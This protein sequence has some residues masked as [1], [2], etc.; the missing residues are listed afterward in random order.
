AAFDGAGFVLGR[1][2]ALGIAREVALKFKEVCVTPA[3]AFSAAEF[4]HGPL[5][6][7]GAGTPLLVLCL[8]DATRPGVID[9]ARR[10]AA[11]GA[12]VTLLGTALDD[13]GAMANLTV[14]SRASTGNLYTDA[15]ALAFDCYVALESRA[16]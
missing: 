7:V 4:I 11:L 3:E 8:N 16:V 1:G 6:L 2:L 15:I 12:H 9:I 14:V 5:T 10:L 13:I